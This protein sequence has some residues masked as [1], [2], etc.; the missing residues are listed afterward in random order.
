M[1]ERQ[2]PREYEIV[3]VVSTLVA[4]DEGIA[5]VLERLRQTIE[6]HGGEVGA[7]NHAAPWGRRKLAYPIREY[8]SGE[9]SRRNFTE[10]FYV[11]MNFKL[12]AAKVIELERTIKLTDTILRY[13]ITVIEQKGGSATADAAEPV[14]ETSE[15]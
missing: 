3:F 7:I 1:R 6:H 5:A 10:G 12:D 8:V 13:L 9:A 11:L 2:R 15:A 4:N 14:A